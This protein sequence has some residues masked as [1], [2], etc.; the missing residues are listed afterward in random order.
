MSGTSWRSWR[1]I[2]ICRSISFSATAVSEPELDL[3]RDGA[4]RRRD[5]ARELLPEL[6]SALLGIASGTAGVR[7]TDAPELAAL[8]ATDRPV[9]A[10]VG[11]RLGSD[12]RPVRAILFDKRPGANWSLDWHQDRTIAVAQR[13]DVRGFGPWSRKQGI[14]HVEPPF[15]LLARMLTVRIHL[16]PVD[17]SNGVLEI[18]PGSHTL[19]R[20]A[21]AA[22]GAVVAA[23]EVRPCSAEAGD[24]W[25][26]ATPILHRSA[27][28]ISGQGRRV[29]QV[30]YSTDELPGGLSWRGV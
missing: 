18:L 4:E 15:E 19:G 21:E 25:V 29:L 22:I 11:E 30:D 2:P 20:L 6:E 10:H 8:L 13:V 16:D 26:Y 9:G 12:A 5:L 14:C 7:I 3:T 17:F 1:A 24:V 27:R 28:T 23:H